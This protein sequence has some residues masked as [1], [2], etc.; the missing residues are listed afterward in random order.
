[1][2][3]HDSFANQKAIERPAN[4][5][6]TTGSKL[7]QPITE[8]ARMWQAQAG[9]IFGQKLHQPGVVSEYVNGPRFDLR[10]DAFVE[11]FDLKRHANM[12]A[13]TLT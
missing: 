5:C 10:Q 13:N 4:T 1:V 12:L 3:H 9:S 11:I 2:Q 6:P 7:E 8:R